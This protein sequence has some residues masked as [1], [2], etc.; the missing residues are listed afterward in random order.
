MQTCYIIISS[1]TII[2][3]PIIAVV[4]GQLLQNRSFK[5]KDKIDI[6]KTLVI[7]NVYDWGSSFRAVDALN[8]IPVIFA[9][10]KTV[11]DKYCA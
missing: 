2:I 11:I 9:D 1:I 5:R 7:Y 10:N 3:A 6:F 8:S 4:I